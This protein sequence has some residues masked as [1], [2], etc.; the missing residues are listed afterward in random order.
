LGFTDQFGTDA[1]DPNKLIDAVLQLLY[2]IPVSTTFRNYL[3][4]TILLG[5]QTSDY[6]WTEAWN[7]YKTTPNATNTNT[8]LTRLQQFYKFI[9]DNPEYQLS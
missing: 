1:A 2:R 3:K 6:Y 9:V 4:T 7:A 8:V 5:G